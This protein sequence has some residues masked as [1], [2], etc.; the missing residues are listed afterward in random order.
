MKVRAPVPVVAAMS[1]RVGRL[2]VY[3]HSVG[4]TEADDAEG[5][6]LLCPRAFA[7]TI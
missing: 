6:P 4:V 7:G 2:L 1:E 3:A 5:L